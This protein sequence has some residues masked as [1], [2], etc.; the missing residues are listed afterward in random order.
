MKTPSL[1]IGVNPIGWSNDDL[2]ELGADISLQRCLSEARTAGYDGIELGH[3]FPREAAALRAALAPHALQLVSGWYSMSLLERGARDELSAMSGHLALLCAMGC[4]VVIVAETTACIHGQRDKPL[5]SRPVMSEEQ[6]PMYCERLGEVSVALREQGLQLAYHH[7][8][9]TVVETQAEIERLLAQ[10]PPEVGLLLD[11]GHLR[12]AGGNPMDILN[13]ARERVV[14]VH[15]K[16]VRSAV[17]EEVKAADTSFLDAVV[18][19]VF[20][21]PGD[22]DIDFESIIR[23]LFE[24]RYAGW[25][26]VEAEQ[27]PAIAD[28]LT[29][30]RAGRR[31]IAGLLA[32]N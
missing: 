18:R 6:W 30:A 10:T 31:H 16:D 4:E 21:I 13:T 3:K 27:D 7:H 20:T 8:M 22:G 14:H 11:T 12:Y 32:G 2:R 17:L 19:G 25:L 15:C 9:G 28:P 29:C 23:R 5:S 26:V 24:H 1:R